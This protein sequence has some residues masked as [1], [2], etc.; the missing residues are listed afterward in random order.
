MKASQNLVGRLNLIIGIAL[1]GLIAGAN[2]TLPF[3]I[4]AIL[5]VFTFVAFLFSKN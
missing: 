1:G 2:A 5:L 4:A 3:M